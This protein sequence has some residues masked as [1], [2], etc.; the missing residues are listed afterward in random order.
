MRDFVYRNMVDMEFMRDE[1][2]LINCIIEIMSE[3]K[4]CCEPFSDMDS[5]SND[6]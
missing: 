1:D 5:T 6:I 2:N 4:M 3:K